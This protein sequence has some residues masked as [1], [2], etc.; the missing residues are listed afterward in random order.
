MPISGIY[1]EEE[2]PTLDEGQLYCFN[3]GQ[4]FNSDNIKFCNNCGVE[5]QVCPISRNKFRIGERFAQC[6]NCQT[7]YHYHHLIDWLNNNDRCPNCRNKINSI[8]KGIV[9]MNYIY[10]P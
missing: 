9:G 7:V 8:H 2:A 4:T 6:P 3:C 10:N 5:I 1:Q